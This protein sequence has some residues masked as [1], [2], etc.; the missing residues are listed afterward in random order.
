[1][2]SGKLSEYIWEVAFVYFTLIRNT[3]AVYEKCFSTPLMSACVKWAKEQL[4]AFNLILSRQLSTV[5]RDGLEWQECM[6]QARENANMLLEVG[7]DFSS[8]IGRAKVV[9]QQPQPVGLGL[10][11]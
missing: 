4:D 2:F 3:V 10:A 11:S 1:V 6:Q 9:E 7:L 8:F 5:P